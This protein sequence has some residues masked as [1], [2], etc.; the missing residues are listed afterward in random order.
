MPPGGLILSN[1]ADYIIEKQEIFLVE[2]ICKAENFGLE[3]VAKLR[4]ANT[5]LCLQH[6][7]FLCS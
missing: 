2:S 1:A 3:E 5:G 6:P 7:L 4:K